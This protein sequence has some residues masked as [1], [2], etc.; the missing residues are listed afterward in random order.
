[1]D[2]GGKKIKKIRSLY[3]RI[4]FNFSLAKEE[5]EAGK[6]K[7]ESKNITNAIMK[8]KRSRVAR[9]RRKYLLQ[10]LRRHS[11]YAKGKGHRRLEN[12]R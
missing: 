3:G 5:M 2:K 11:T 10:M 1:M 9:Q 12:K 4:S 8:T 6:K 7:H